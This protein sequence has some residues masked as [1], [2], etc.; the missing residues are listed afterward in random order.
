MK[1]SAYGTESKS[2]SV[3]RTYMIKVPSNNELSPKHYTSVFCN[4]SKTLKLNRL[5]KRMLIHIL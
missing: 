3:Q 4:S 2:K 1:K 5:N